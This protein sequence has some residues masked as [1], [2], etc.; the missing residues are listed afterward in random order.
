MLSGV[1]WL[2]IS[3]IA[4]FAVAVVAVVPIFRDALKRRRMAENLRRQ[5]R[6]QLLLA[7]AYIIKRTREEKK[8]TPLQGPE[9]E[10]I[11]AIEQLFKQSHIL[12]SQEHESIGS[13]A[14]HLSAFSRHSNPQPEAAQVLVSA[15]EGLVRKFGGERYLVK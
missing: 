9:L 12:K 1:N 2:A 7:H 15:L 8:Y 11:N 13:I 6:H 4:T 5:I 14:L 10:P 3:G